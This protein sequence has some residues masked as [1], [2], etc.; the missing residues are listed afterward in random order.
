MKIRLFICL[1]LLLSFGVEW[2]HPVRADG[3]TAATLI[4]DFDSKDA[5]DN[6]WSYLDDL[7]DGTV[8][9]FQRDTHTSFN[10]SA[11]L[12][13][14]LDIAAGSYAGLGYD[15]DVYPDWT[16]GEGLIFQVRASAPGIP[17]VMVIHLADPSQTSPESPGVTPFGCPFA[18]PPGSENDW[19][20]VT[21]PWDGFERQMW[22]GETGLMEFTPNPI[23][24]IEIAVEASEDSRLAG[25]VWLD[26]LRVISEEDLN[27]TPAVNP[28]AADVPALVASQ[29]GYRPADPKRFVTSSPVQAFSIV[30]DATGKT[31]YNGQTTRWG[32][33]EDSDQ[34][35][36]WG[37]FDALT[38]PGRYRIVIPDVGESA[39]FDIGPDVFA[40]PLNMAARAFYLH[41]SGTAIED[42]AVS[43]W[44][45]AAGH[46]QPAIL[47]EDRSIARDVYGGWYD[48]GDFGRYMPTGA[49]STSQ[50]LY[51][52]RA[53]PD[54][55]A[56]GV[57]QIPESG[58]GTPD[59]LDEIRWELE[60]MQRMQGDDGAVYHK[61]TTRDYPDYGIMPDADTGQLY[62]F[63]PTSADTAYFAAVMAQAAPYYEA[64]DPA[65]AAACLAAAENAWAWLAAHPEQVP[66]GGFQNP[67]VSEFPMQGGYDF[68]GNE[69]GHRLWAAAQ[70][71]NTTGDPRYAEAFAE[72]L[73]QAADE[74]TVHTMSWAD[75]YAL[76][77]FA[78]L[79][80]QETDPSVW[81]QAA[82][83]FKREADAILNVTLQSGYEVALHGRSGDFA[84]VWGSNQV[85]LANGLYLMLANEL[86]PDERYVHAARAQVQ[87]IL[88][89]NPLGKM[90][91]TGLGANPALHPHHTMSFGLQQA[92]PGLVGEGANGAV[93]F[94]SGGDAV[95]E[96]LWAAN[97]PAALCYADNW[98]SWATNEPTI[99]A[100]A[101]FVA[102][103]SYFAP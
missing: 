90:Y 29:T 24:G 3:P 70:L 49:F 98:E 46:L 71:F 18:T 30:D 100:N 92:M 76:G 25:T 87:Y 84:Y 5:L 68:Y 77:L 80:A 73:L 12:R 22:V 97:T 45:H 81:Q 23:T 8:F 93:E 86:F 51:A 52:Y 11:S 99:D 59:L 101:S 31:V 82:D 64:Y 13:L 4:A 1:T 50:L 27:A 66:E 69:A 58:N 102:L 44:S 41:R 26:D 61:V 40:Q 35:L 42:T 89:L 47:W 20:T 16:R 83:I 9:Q 65:F 32:Y 88:G 74:K 57:L 19:I 67:P 53:N 7:P 39:P 28:L 21:L 55:F 79:T 72:L 56:D 75:S 38:T 6:W 37:N 43:G 33:D 48:A 54:F 103:A 96:A 85:A 10:G 78:F 2:W 63:G 17:L 95:L 34:T 91:F 62:L 36:Y 94:G 14:D 15:Y 60:W